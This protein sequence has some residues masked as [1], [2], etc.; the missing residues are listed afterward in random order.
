MER[1][2]IR[3]NGIVQG[4]G[5][6]PFIHRLVSEHRLN[7]MIRNNSSGVELPH[8]GGIG[9]ILSHF[10]VSEERAEQIQ[11]ICLQCG[12]C[13]TTCAVDMPIPE[14]IM[15]LRKRKEDRAVCGRNSFESARACAHQ[16]AENGV[17]PAMCRLYRLHHYGKRTGGRAEHPDFTGSVYL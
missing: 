11:N 5:F 2:R 10:L 6:R 1:A 17:R 12:R 16:R 13:K 8:T 9:T 7:G 4:V 15:K 14:M 3:I